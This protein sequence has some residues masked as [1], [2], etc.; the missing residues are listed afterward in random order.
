MTPSEVAERFRRFAAIE[1][2][3]SPLYRR[4]AE[5]I[6]EDADLVALA[7]RT[8]PGQPVPNMLLAA[9][10]DLLL[11]GLAHP[12]ASFYPSLTPEPVA[13]DP[14]PA[15]RDLCL[16]QQDAIEERLVTRRVQTNEVARC[17]CFAP[18]LALAGRDR[19]LALID[20]GASAGLHLL[21]DRYGYEYS[22]GRRFGPAASGVGLRCELRGAERPALPDRVTVAARVGVDIHPVDVRDPQAARWLLAL[23]WPDQPERAERVRAAMA[24]A[25]SDPPKLEAGNALDVLPAVM[26]EAP[27]EAEV[28]V[29]H[30]HTLNQ[31]SPPDRQ[32]F[33]AV[34][35]GGGRPVTE[36]AIEWSAG[37]PAPRLSLTRYRGGRVR[38][39]ILGTCDA[40]GEWLAWG[41]APQ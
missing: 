20:V 41:L 25:V 10:H 23:V 30:C 22:D 13:A 29:L 4:L 8:A 21:W 33:A 38:E 37:E 9:A 15:F 28:C 24:V 17:A 19:P 7:G 39:A 12:L 5:G 26:A 11:G 27:S 32:R 2:D 14:L 40:H 16:S 1:C 31:F 36:V 34:L 6:A 35:A 3:R 18:A